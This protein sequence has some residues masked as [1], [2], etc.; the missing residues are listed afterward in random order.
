MTKWDQKMD[1]L[2]NRLKQ[3]QSSDGS[4]LSVRHR[5]HNRCLH[6]HSV[7][8]AGGSGRPIDPGARAKNFKQ[9]DGCK[10]TIK[11]YFF[12]SHKEF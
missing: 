7:K 12:G 4:G 1:W 6:D 8:D 2:I 11:S 5:H 9:T 3:D 10:Q